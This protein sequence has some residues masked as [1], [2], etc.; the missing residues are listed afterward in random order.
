MDPALQELYESGPEDE[1][2]SVILRLAEGADAPEGVQ[3]VSRFGPIATARLA[4]ARI[5]A[6][7]AS[8]RVESV[9][10]PRPIHEP[11][12]HAPPA[13]LRGPRGAGGEA[14]G[15]DVEG[16]AAPPSPVT[17]PPYAEDGAGVVVGVC[18][19]GL[20]FTHPNFRNADGTTRVRALW[21]QRRGADPASPQPYGYGRLLT[22]EAIDA[23]LATSDPFGAAG[24]DPRDADPT[25][26]GSHGTAVTDIVAGN[27]R[28]PGSEVGLAGG[29]EI[30]FVHLAAQRLRPLE[31][32]GDSVTLLE[33]IDFC[34]RQA[35]DRPCVLHLSAGKM[36]GP[37]CG[38][39]LVERAIDAMLSERDG[40]FFGQSAG[41][42][43]TSATHTHGRLGPDQRQ[44]LHWLVP[45]ED[46][47]PNELEV[48][49][50][51]EDRF[52]VRLTSPEGHEFIAALG[53]RARVTDGR[54]DWG[55]LYHRRREPNSGLNHVDIVLRPS[56]PAGDWRLELHGREVVDGRF[57]SWIE[58]D[59]GSRYQSRF[60]RWQATSRFT[61]NTIC[62]S[63]RAVAVGAYDGTRRGRPP[64][65]FSSRGPTVDGRQKPELAAPGKR[66]RAARSTPRDDAQGDRWFCVKSGTSLAAPF[67]SGTAALV[68][69]AA[70][71]LL[72]IHE[73]RRILM[74]TVDPAPAAPGRRS[75]TALGY[76]YLNTAAAVAAARRVRDAP[77]PD[78]ADADGAAVAAALERSTG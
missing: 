78:R 22:R 35:E 24:Y 43:A 51:G 12:L 18:D 23:A 50:S 61:T 54:V 5:P 67:V 62:N 32:L 75:S 25:G 29:A 34:R 7:W 4:R 57:H 1:V 26:A 31:N 66:I 48:W 33:G 28:Q 11:R 19:W 2:V 53:S 42:Y 16:G 27:R 73:T 10:A 56:A 71:R 63:F 41:N 6:T 39:T 17:H 64:A 77:P 9:K 47:T 40:I 70:G 74:G 55:V 21:D 52:D 13:R 60:P 76:G 30:V 68:F 58:R 36:A 15:E 14:T 69:Q 59:V 49:Y 72:G 3:I 65:P 44:V 37:H 38:C 45:V 46:R 20:D 8:D